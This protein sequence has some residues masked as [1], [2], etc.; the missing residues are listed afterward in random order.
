MDIKKTLDEKLSKLSDKELIDYVKDNQE[1]YEFNKDKIIVADLTVS[2][3][4]ATYKAYK[5]EI[6]KRGLNYE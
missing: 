1:F 5:Q 6:K 3:I 2:I 4:M